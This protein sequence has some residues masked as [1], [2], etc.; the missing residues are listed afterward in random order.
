MSSCS[1]LVQAYSTAS[2]S[3]NDGMLQSVL[4]SE[5]LMHTIID[6]HCHCFIFAYIIPITTLVNI[7]SGFVVARLAGISCHAHVYMYVSS[8]CIGLAGAVSHEHLRFQQQDISLLSAAH[9][10]TLMS[11]LLAEEMV[12]AYFKLTY[13]SGQA[14][15]CC[16]LDCPLGATGKPLD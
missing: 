12:T 3:P 13:C 8:A 10:T 14:S 4:H 1:D 15:W 6:R 7:N 2:L 11:A 5:V 9:K 16:V